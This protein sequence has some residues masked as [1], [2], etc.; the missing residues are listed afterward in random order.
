MVIE[1]QS[2]RFIEWAK[3]II[4]ELE[5]SDLPALHDIV[6]NETN[7]LNFNDYRFGKRVQWVRGSDR[8]L[9]YVEVYD[10]DVISYDL[11]EISITLEM[12][13]DTVPCLDCGF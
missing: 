4:T 11:S 12:L 8:F 7:S 9:N 10:D 13:A 2:P 6:F 1:G 3:I 5:V